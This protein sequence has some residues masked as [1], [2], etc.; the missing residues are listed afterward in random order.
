MALLST[1]LDELT[2]DERNEL[3]RIPELMASA[4]QVEN[5]ARRIAS[6]H[7]AASRCVVLG[8]GYS[9]ATAREWALKLLELSQLPALPFSAADF[10][11]GPLALA[12]PGLPVL[13][14]APA[15]AELDAQIELLTRLRRKQRVR[16]VTISDANEAL[17]IDQGL[18]LPAGIAGWLSPL[19]EVIPAQL[20]TYYLT[21][22]RGLNPDRPRTISKVTRTT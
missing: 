1:A 15:G 20:Y 8:R 14:V 7:A 21:I 4:L 22:A 19:A 16:L 5:D 17:G 18:A 10:E 11:H 2:A 13:A 3:S 9:Y 12:E 6:E